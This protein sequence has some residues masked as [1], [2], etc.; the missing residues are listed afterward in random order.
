[1]FETAVGNS[2]EKLRLQ[3]KV[4]ETG[5]VDADIRTLLVDILSSSGG[6]SLLAGGGGGRLV[7]ELVVRVVDE[8]FLGRHDGS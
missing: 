1:M 4:A 2:T 7:V 5:G 6:I 3:Q 8:I